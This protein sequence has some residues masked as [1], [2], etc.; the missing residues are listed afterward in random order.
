M[1]QRSNGREMS[2][3]K[4]NL[5]RCTAIL[6]DRNFLLSFVDGNMQG[7]CISSMVVQSRRQD[8]GNSTFTRS[9]CR[10]D[11]KVPSRGSQDQNW[12]FRARNVGWEDIWA[13]LYGDEGAAVGDELL[14]QAYSF[15]QQEGEE[16]SAFASRLDNQI[17]AA[18]NHGAELLPD[19]ETGDRHLRPK[20]SD[21]TDWLIDQ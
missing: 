20:L 6:L 14:S 18:K 1:V 13:A 3:W 7:S 5:Y 8:S 2:S 15:Q 17:W 12:W 4:F 9:H 10:G 19:E 16:V 21:V 11:S